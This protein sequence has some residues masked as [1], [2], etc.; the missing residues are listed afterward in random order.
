ME[1]I[2][3]KWCVSEEAFS[4]LRSPWDEL[5]LRSRA[6]SLFRGF[7]WQWAAW[8]FVAKPRGCLL[9]LL[10]GRAAGRVVLI[11][12][13][14]LEGRFLRFLSSEKFEYRDVL[15]E[16][17][18]ATEAWVQLA[19]SHALRLRGPH[20]LDLR[21]MS[22]GCALDRALIARH[23]FRLADESPLIRLGRFADWNEYARHL[24]PHMLADQRRQWRR[25]R[26][27]DGAFRFRLADRTELPALVDWLFERKLEWA[28]RRHLRAG[29]LATEAY[30]T[31]MKTVLDDAFA[32]DR[33]I[34]GCIDGGGGIA[35]AGF[36][37]IQDKRF[38]FYMFAY[39]P[40]FAAVSPSRLLTEEL[41]R[42]S[43][44]RGLTSFD[45]LP[46]EE[47]YKR[48]WADD[49]TPVF[50]V[51]R[52]LTLRGC[53]SLFWTRDIVAWLV[54]R[55]WLLGLYAAMPIGFRARLRTRLAANWDLVA[56]L[57]AHGE[58]GRASES[59]ERASGPRP[60]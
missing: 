43:M 40:R 41:I 12:P 23:G 55:R 20:Y 32:S 51:F 2:D 57:N 52:P 24:P 36:G 9:R 1:P 14:V 30:R 27:L 31:F 39:E 58:S 15:V 47:A 49:A 10:I 37:F 18:A 33:A 22:K 16:E 50:D 42:W 4:A 54:R 38:I 46:G 8:Q 11:L 56:R 44:A 26:Q 35:S 19:V 53:A 34:V 17:N 28:N 5:W 6:P 13:L 59:G 21:C 3:F 29:V 25:L 48:V 60:G 7:A 45:F